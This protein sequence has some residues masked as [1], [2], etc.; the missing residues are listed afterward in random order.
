M[1]E[2]IDLC[3]ICAAMQWRSLGVFPGNNR[4]ADLLRRVGFTVTFDGKNMVVEQ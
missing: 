4:L 2:L 1:S 3:C